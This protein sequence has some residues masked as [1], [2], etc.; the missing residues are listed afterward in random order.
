MIVLGLGYAAYTYGMTRV[1]DTIQVNGETVAVETASATE[2]GESSVAGL[3]PE[4][5]ADWQRFKQTARELAPQYDYPVKVIIAQAALESSRGTS[6]FARERFNYFG[7]G[8]FD[9]APDRAY[10]YDNIEHGI[11]EYMR[12][13]QERFPEA[14]AARSNPDRMIELLVENKMGR[15]YATDPDYVAKL[16]DL[17]EW[18]ES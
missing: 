10:T 12:F 9:S 13:V 6:R 14:Y 8:A 17:P 15:K 4:Q 18:K 11:I 7:I 1:S 5:D 2:A 16:R 3:T